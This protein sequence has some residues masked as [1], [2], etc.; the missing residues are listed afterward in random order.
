MNENNY[1]VLTE[2]DEDTLVYISVS[3]GGK[4]NYEY[5][6]ESEGTLELLPVEKESIDAIKYSSI[7]E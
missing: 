7:F 5:Y 4:F 6:R 3:K 2:L 1:G